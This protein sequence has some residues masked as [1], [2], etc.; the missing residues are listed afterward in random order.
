MGKRHKKVEGDTVNHPAHYQTERFE[1]VDVMED[2]TDRYQDGSVASC[3]SHALTYLWRAP[4]CGNL[5]ED[6]EKCGWWVMRAVRRAKQL[7]LKRNA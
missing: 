6:L 3:I 7:E 5:I 2:V 4:V 1:C